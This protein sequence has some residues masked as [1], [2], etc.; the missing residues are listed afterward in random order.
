MT[1]RALLRAARASI[2][3]LK[4]YVGALDADDLDDEAAEHVETLIAL[5]ARLP[6]AKAL[7]RTPPR[8]LT[9]G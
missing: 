7:R 3:V 8:P 6:I 4:G 1:S 5:A 9:E 2:D